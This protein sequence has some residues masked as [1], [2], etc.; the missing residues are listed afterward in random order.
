LGFSKVNFGFGF[1]GSAGFTLGA[2]VV[3]VVTFSAE[4]FAEHPDNTTSA[5]TNP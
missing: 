5:I 4:L 2:V 3:V 1:S